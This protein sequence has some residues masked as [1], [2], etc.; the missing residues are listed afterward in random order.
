M[1]QSEIYNIVSENELTEV[2]AHFNTEF[3]MSIIDNAIAARFNPSSYMM[4]PNVV[5][6]WNMNFKQIIEYYN[7][8]DMT[9]RMMTLRADTYKEI[10]DRIC[11]YHNLNFTIEEVDLYSA[12]RYLY[13]FFV[14]GF[15]TY[16]NQFFANYI[17]KEADSIYE[18]MQLEVLRKKKDSSTIYTRKVYRNDK[19][20][21]IVANIDA[22]VS[23]IGGMDFDFPYIVNNSGLTSQEASFL[24]SLV[25]PQDDFFKS[26]YMRV[27]SDQFF[28]R[29]IHLN[30]IRFIIRNIADPSDE[31]INALANSM[32]TDQIDPIV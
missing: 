10:I 17:I 29:P 7:C 2:I 27:L 15:L 4:Y 3:I 14:C 25:S 20:A 31:T 30:N 18:A 16:M 24:L 13:Q 9:E 11:K 5:D 6:A 22:V 26:Q 19:L 28:V 12:A 8:V 21:V 32:T 23:Y 1:N